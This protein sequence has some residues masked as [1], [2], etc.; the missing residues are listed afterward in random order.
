MSHNHHR[1]GSPV[2]L[3]GQHGPSIGAVRG[4]TMLPS[5]VNVAFSIV[6]ENVTAARAASRKDLAA[7]DRT[8]T[9]MVLFLLFFFFFLPL[10]FVLASLSDSDD[11]A[12][13]DSLPLTA[14]AA[15]L[16]PLCVIRH[17]SPNLQIPRA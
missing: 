11:V 9:F 13:D 4:L 17:A 3:A 6:L 7:Q 5:V 12:L 8:R 14:G 16:P 2:S 15:R 10:F 1:V